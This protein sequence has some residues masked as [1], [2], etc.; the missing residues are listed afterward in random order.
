MDVYIGEQESSF[1]F[2]K[3]FFPKDVNEMQEFK[4]E[5]ELLNIKMVFTEATD[6]FGRITIYK[7][8]FVGK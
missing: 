1:E 8:D 2:F 7:L 3:S 5:N 6:F 4:I